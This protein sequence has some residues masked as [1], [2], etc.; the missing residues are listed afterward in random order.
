[1]IDSEGVGMTPSIPICLKDSDLA[2]FYV[3]DLKPC[4]DFKIDKSNRFPKDGI[5]SPYSLNDIR[6]KK[7]AL[8]YFSMPISDLPFWQT[9]IKGYELW[10]PNIKVKKAFRT[11]GMI[12]GKH[13][14]IFVMEDIQK[15]KN[16]H[17]YQF[18]A[19]LD[20]D[21]IQKS[22]NFD[23]KLSDYKN[24]IIIGAN[25]KPENLLVRLLQV[26]D[27]SAQFPGKV[28]KYTLT[29]P[30]QKDKEINKLTINSTSVAPDF[31]VLFFPHKE[32]EV[33][34]KTSWNK[35]KTVLKVEWADQQ[36]E[37]TFT[38]QPDGR[39]SLKVMRSG[40][41]IVNTL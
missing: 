26:S 7:S 36:D 24:D 38:K 37:L 5:K 29:N 25:G 22:T 34:P 40:K 17:L 8:P 21:L 23:N 18:G 10:L 9:S 20:D 33:L 6:L 31:K 12:R 11:T 41:E 15:D 27:D 16:A 35:A 13:T 19:I 4:Y 30:G 39:T 3:S 32:G 2:T 14:Y 1:L 28:F